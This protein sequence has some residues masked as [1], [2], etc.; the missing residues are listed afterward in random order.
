[1]KITSQEK[2]VLLGG[3]WL[4]WLSAGVNVGFLILYGTS[5][6][7]LTGDISNVA[8]DILTF[9]RESQTALLNLG[10]ATAGFLSGAGFAGYYIHHPS[11]ELT[12]PYG[13]TFIIIGGLLTLSHACLGWSV[14]TAILLASSACGLQNAMATHYRG[15]VLRT[16][17][18]TGLITDLG[19]YAG[20]KLRG[21]PVSKAKILIPLVLSLSFFGG[22]LFGA[23]IVLWLQWPFL[24][25]LAAIYVSGGIFYVAMKP[26]LTRLPAQ[27]RR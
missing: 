9:G 23:A 8:V 2:L 15:V 7:H 13:R 19:S 10:L 17:H 4:A 24:L 6:S 25:V 3:C 12:R 22:S 14:S 5:V 20:M 11:L 27:K 16:T 21:H 26:R 1:M 18:L